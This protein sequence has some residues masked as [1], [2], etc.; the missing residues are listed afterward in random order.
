[1]RPDISLVINIIE[2]SHHS[3]ITSQYN[4]YTYTLIPD[5]FYYLQLHISLKC[6]LPNWCKNR[7]WAIVPPA[8][9][10]SAVYRG[11]I[12]QV[13]VNLIQNASHHTSSHFCF[14]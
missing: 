9:P 5:T 13:K 2:H 10:L 6:S 14:S 3:Y 1:M 7:K 11:P 4:T 12:E 8:P